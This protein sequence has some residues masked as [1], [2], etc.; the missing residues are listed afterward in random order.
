M[1]YFFLSRK[2]IYKNKI[3]F[4][5]FFKLVPVKKN[6]SD[7][8]RKPKASRHTEELKKVKAIKKICFLGM[9]TFVIQVSERLT[10]TGSR[11]KGGGG[12]GRWGTKFLQ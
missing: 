1:F 10:M 7:I 9:Y 8:N 6:S 11:D 2:N 12:V 4:A 5:E 3:N